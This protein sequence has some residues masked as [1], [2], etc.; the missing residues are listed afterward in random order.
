MDIYQ[1]LLRGGNEPLELIELLKFV[2][3]YSTLLII[4]YWQLG[5][6]VGLVSLHRITDHCRNHPRMTRSM[7]ELASKKVTGTVISYY[8][9]SMSSPRESLL[10]ATA[11]ERK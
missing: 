6:A 2:A 11:P 5:R 9:N 7:Q 8:A 4:R 1:V 3:I 10:T